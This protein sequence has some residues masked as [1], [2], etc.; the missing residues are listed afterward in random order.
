MPGKFTNERAACGEDEVNG[1]H[2]C[3]MLMRDSVVQIDEVT[4][5]R[6][7]NFEIK[8]KKVQTKVDVQNDLVDIVTTMDEGSPRLRICSRA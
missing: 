4:Q 8:V 6:G 3:D 5:D 7:E 1:K 2:A